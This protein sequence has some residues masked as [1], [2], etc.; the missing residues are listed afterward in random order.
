METKTESG[1]ETDIT[2]IENSCSSIEEI[3]EGSDVENLIHVRVKNIKEERF[4][5]VKL[6]KKNCFILN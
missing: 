1:S 5:F 4:V 6:G 2:L 3:F